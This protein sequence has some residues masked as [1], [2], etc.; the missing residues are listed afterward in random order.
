M[1]KLIIDF[2]YKIEN[3]FFIFFLKSKKIK[4]LKNVT[5]FEEF[6]YMWSLKKGSKSLKSFYFASIAILP[7]PV[8]ISAIEQNI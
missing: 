5:V 8:N 4:V 6:D 1:K 7:E 3:Y 2:S